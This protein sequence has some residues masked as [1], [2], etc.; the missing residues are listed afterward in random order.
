MSFKGL[1]RRLFAKRGEFDTKVG[2]TWQYEII[3][4]GKT[5]YKSKP[6]HNVTTDAGRNAARQILHQTNNGGIAGFQYIAVGST[7]YTPQASDTT[8]TGE[9][10]GSGLA[11]TQGTYSNDTGTGA[12]KV[13]NTFTYTGTG[14]TIYTGALFN[15]SSGGTMLYAA[16]FSSSATL[17]QNDQLKVTISGTV[18]A[19]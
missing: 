6:V 11:R 8:L 9:V 2:T 18:G 15:A 7:D 10:T 17:A 19:A 16:K 12:W 1:M 4:N 5:I 3:R 13:E 14:I